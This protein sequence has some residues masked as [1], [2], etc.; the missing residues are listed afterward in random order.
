MLLSITLDKIVTGI[1]ASGCDKIKYTGSKS[2]SKMS[3][4]DWNYVAFAT[5]IPG[6]DCPSPH[7][8]QT[9]SYEAILKSTDQEC[10]RFDFLEVKLS[11]RI[12]TSNWKQIFSFDSV[13]RID[14]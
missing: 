8:Q 7:S 14:I 6:K 1:K 11:Q 10:D 12:V 2:C 5:V 9:S 3:G 13:Q 4:F